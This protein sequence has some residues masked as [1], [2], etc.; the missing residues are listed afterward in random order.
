MN[1]PGI[2]EQERKK[3]LLP[4]QG[5]INMVLDTDTFNEVDDQFALSYALMS[6]EKLN[7][8][9]VYA[10]PFSSTFFAKLLGE[11]NVN[12]PMTR[13]LKEGLE[14]SYQ[15]II[16]IYRM[17][18]KSPEGNVFRGSNQYLSAPDK[19]IE[20]AAA[21]DL[22]KRAMASDKLLYV[23]AIGEIT[24]IASAIMMEP[25]IIDKIVVVWLAG[26]PMQWPQTIEFNLGQDLIASQF[27]LNCGVPLVLIPC[28]TVASHL[29]TTG[30]ELKENLYNKSEIGTYLTET[31]T[32]QFSPE[33]AEEFM[34]VI[35]FT[36]LKDVDDY[37]ESLTK[38]PL[39][40]FACSRIIWDISVIGYLLNPNWCPSKLMPAPRLTPELTWEHDENRHLIRVCQYVFRDPIF[41]DMFTK[42]AGC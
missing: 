33:A 12:I 21:Q 40:R 34:D 28:M 36:Y 26:Q 42:L 1:I 23:A 5:E 17:L 37:D 32:S 19:P 24:N 11:E 18:K 14:L 38:S 13:D 15:E 2:S 25:K 6:P 4:P 7:V 30:P 20:S 16:K 9:A 22:I 10:A 8:Q 39:G 29:T 41:G 35:R 31:V 3:R 27:I